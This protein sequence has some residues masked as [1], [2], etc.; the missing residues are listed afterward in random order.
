MA[1]RD[2]A[3]GM[4]F[5][6]QTIV[7]ILGNFSLLFHYVFLYFTKCRLRSTRLILTHL[8]VAN[9]LV[10]LSRG[11]PQTMEAFG[12]KDFLNDFGC[13]LVFYVHRV[14]RGMSMGTTCLLSIYQVIIISPGNSRWTELK[15]KAPKYVGFSIL[16]CWTLHL[17]S[18]TI[19][20]VC[21]NGNGGNQSIAKNRD[22]V[23]CSA[24][25]LDSTMNS[26]IA[27][28]L[29]FP[30]SVCLGLMIWA[31]G[32]MVFI[33]YRHQQR[34]QHI[35]TS[36]IALRSSPETRA[37]QAILVFLSVFVSLYTLSTTLQ[38][39]VTLFKN[40]GWWL[41]SISPLC[42]ACF[43]TV[44]PFVLMRNELRNA[45]WCSFAWVLAGRLCAARSVERPVSLQYS[46]D[47]ALRGPV[48]YSFFMKASH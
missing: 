38:I 31:S 29:S 17:L 47:R 27:V 3:I 35:H 14:G 32:S 43:P 18:S 36:N 40:S 44:S 28:L 1:S 21:V 26:L 16:L 12:W 30:D 7:G 25:I 46:V 19:C 23:Y 15:V 6:S 10:L 9:S 42:A 39:C 33:L 5:L 11:I 2:L 4:I 22:F 37:T 13:K 48:N 45:S 8:T 41:V 20:I 24:V 34:V